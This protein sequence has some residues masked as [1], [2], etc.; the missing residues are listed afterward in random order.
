MKQY[1]E[2]TGTGDLNLNVKVGRNSTTIKL[3]NTMCM[4]QLRNNL[5]SV[6]R[7]TE[8]DYAVIFHKDCAIVKRRDG[9]VVLTATKQ[10]QLFIVDTTKNN[11]MTMRETKND[12]LI[13]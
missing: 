8:N 2:F 13:R 3:Q 11:V 9:S 12:N 10:N 4:L 1:I 5:M 7:I 6:R